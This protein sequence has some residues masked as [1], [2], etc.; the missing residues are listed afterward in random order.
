M[1]C[2]LEKMVFRD[3]DKIT[4]GTRARGPATSQVAVL[5]LALGLL[6]G[7]CQPCQGLCSS[8]FLSH[9]STAQLRPQSSLLFW[10]DN[11]SEYAKLKEISSVFLTEPIESFLGIFVIRK[12]FFPFVLFLVW[13]ILFAFLIFLY[14]LLSILFFEIISLLFPFLPSNPLIY[15]PCSLSNLGPSFHCCQM[16]IYLNT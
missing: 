10:D 12:L 15:P 3:M 8:L 2:F 1:I 16:H 11:S 5:P 6:A 4:E 14:F 13:I 9:N 7:T